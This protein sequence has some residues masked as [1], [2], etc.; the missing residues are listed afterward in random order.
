MSINE[1]VI[2]RII[3]EE[4]RRVLREG[5]VVS[6][7]KLVGDLDDAGERELSQRVDR[8]NRQNGGNI[9][10]EF[11]VRDDR[12]ALYVNDKGRTGNYMFDIPLDVYE[13]LGLGDVSMG[14]HESDRG[15]A[16]W[17]SHDNGMDLAGDVDPRV[18]RAW[19][20]FRSPCRE[21]QEFGDM[22]FPDLENDGEPTSIADA[23]TGLASFW[24]NG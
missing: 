4:T 12:V 22:E 23:A 16:H 11:D 7:S 18:S 24:L 5:K 20:N 10:V 6:A 3:R 15:P 1:S 2:R 8:Y 19:S 9:G 21:L 14:L 17:A 13:Q